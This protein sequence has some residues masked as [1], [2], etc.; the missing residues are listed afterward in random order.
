MRARPLAIAALALVIGAYDGFFG[1]GT[2]TFLDRRLRRAVRQE[3]G[4]TRPPTPR[5]STSRRTSRA[6]IVFARAGTILW[7]ISLPMAVGQ[8]CGGVLG[9]QLAMRGGARLVR[10]CVLAVSAALVVK[11]AYDAFF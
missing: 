10:V 4:R 1:P 11:L 5:S 9:A 8:L 2:G 6:V 7:E 3:P